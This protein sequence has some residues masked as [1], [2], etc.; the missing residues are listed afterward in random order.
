MWRRIVSR[1]LVTADEGAGEGATEG[2]RRAMGQWSHISRR[3]HVTRDT[4]GCFG[5]MPA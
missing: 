5:T 2:S 3:R 4:E 1:A